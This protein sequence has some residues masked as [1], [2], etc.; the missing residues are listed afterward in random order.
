MADEINDRQFLFDTWTKVQ[1][2]E[3]LNAVER[4][5]KKII[6]MHPQ[7]HSV[8]ANPEAY[9]THEFDPNETDPFSHLGLH[10]IVME[11]VSNDSPPGFRAL[12]DQRV[13]QT[14]DKHEVQHELMLAVFDWLVDHGETETND[15]TGFLDKLKKQFNP[16]TI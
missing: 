9:A 13:S 15:E 6:E 12:Y 5:M 10:A 11:M 16:T 4:L 14:G 8:L 2:R 1:N 7:M 3:K